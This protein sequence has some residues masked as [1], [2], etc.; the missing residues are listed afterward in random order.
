MKLAILFEVYIIFAVV[1]MPVNKV[2]MHVA[3]R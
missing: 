2:Y 1:I 3:T